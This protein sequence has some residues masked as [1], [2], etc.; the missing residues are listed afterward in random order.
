MIIPHTLKNR[1][2][3]AVLNYI[4]P[5]REVN[6]FIE[7]DI[8]SYGL[9]GDIVTMYSFG[10]AWDYLVLRYYENYMVTTN[11]PGGD[12][13]QVAAFLKQQNMLCL[14][15]KEDIL[16]G[17]QQFWPDV[18]VQGTYL[19]RLDKEHFT[20][21]PFSDKAVVRLAADDSRTII[22][23]YKQIEEFARPYIEHE[24][25]KLKQTR[26]LLENGGLGFGI[27]N[28]ENLVCMA[29]ITAKTKSGAMIIGVAT[30]P[31]YRSRGYASQVM[32]RLCSQC[33]S[34][35]LSFLCLFYDNPLAGAIYHRLG[36][37]TI[38]RWG[39]LKF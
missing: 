26:E 2:I 24:Q 30:H 25:D 27:F 10:E 14:S 33:F 6:L 23:L 18:P 28:E 31:S 15:A 17:M 4:A 34:D 21:N 3:P 20:S 37:E 36:F 35:G 12:L 19:C 11:K 29:T 38:G 13:S 9:E 7:G 5:E 32:S 16:L 8:E 39:M 1:D 22:D